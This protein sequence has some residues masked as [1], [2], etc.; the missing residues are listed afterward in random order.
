M[1]EQIAPANGLELCYESIGDPDDPALLMVMG[2]G[3]QLVGWPDALCD[4]FA[5]RGFRVVRFDN[6]DAG[7]STHL[8]DARRPD[9]RAA[10]EGDVSSAAYTLSD[11]AADTAGLLD[12]LG[13]E[14]AHVLGSSMGGMVAQMLAIE[15]PR[16]VASLTSLMSTTGSPS[17]GRAT[18]E[19]E[20]IL[21]QPPVRSREEY[22]ERSVANSAITGS[23]GF[24]LDEDGA[25]H[26]AGLSF[27]RGYDPLGVARQ[28]VAVLASPDRTAGL[29]TVAVPTLV[30][31][32][33]ADPLID[34][35]GGRATADAVPGAELEI[36][37][38]MG[39]DLPVP[40]WAPL[41]ERVTRLAA[42]TASAG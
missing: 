11:L 23:P 34:V 15:H 27:D 6:R 25:R 9:V 31:H 4:G 39:H 40:I 29:A 13:I 2:L 37:A 24:E 16:R 33:D 19:A 21:T 8:H 3:A 5:A 36:V 12:A 30:W 41:V 1:T 17:V 26:R 14:R 42:R 35:S 10:L 28:L 22:V 38:G 18:L 20:A 7:R 32:G